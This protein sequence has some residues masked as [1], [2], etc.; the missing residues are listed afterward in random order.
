MIFRTV[1]ESECSVV[2]YEGLSV[3]MAKF[4]FVFWLLEFLQTQHV[5][6]YEW[7][8]GNSI[9]SILKHG[10]ENEMVESIFMDD[11]LLALGEQYQPKVFEARYGVLGKTTSGDILFVCFTIRGNRIRPISSRYANLREREIY[12]KEIC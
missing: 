8:D 7:D 1:C 5:F 12:E 3:L 6:E 10:V 4:R 2:H 11:N 9:K